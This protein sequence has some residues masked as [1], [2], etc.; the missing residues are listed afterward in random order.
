MDLKEIIKTLMLSDLYFSLPL[1]ERKAVVQRLWSQYGKG[2]LPCSTP[3]PQLP[4]ELSRNH[5]D[6]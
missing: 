3:W 1:E 4:P 2:G 5:D 6:E